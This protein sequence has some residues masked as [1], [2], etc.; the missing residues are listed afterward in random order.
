M[1]APL[2]IVT[3]ET[4][5][6]GFPHQYGASLTFTLST[7]YAQLF[8]VS[9]RDSVASTLELTAQNFVSRASLLD[10]PRTGD[11]YRWFCGIHFP[12]QRRGDFALLFPL[13]R[14]GK[15]FPQGRSLE[16]SV[17]AYSTLPYT[18]SSVYTF[19]CAF[20]ERLSLCKK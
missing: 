16:R 12:S 7:A 11:A 18:Y 1:I 2:G 19:L 20:A 4:A 3:K 13:V 5:F 8:P 17:N 6:R 15:H 14:A 10:R 9:S